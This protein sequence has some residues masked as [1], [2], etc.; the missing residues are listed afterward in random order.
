MTLPCGNIKSRALNVGRVVLTGDGYLPRTV[1]GGILYRDLVVGFRI[2]LVLGFGGLIDHKRDVKSF[3]VSVANV[4]RLGIKNF[5][6]RSLPPIIVG[7]G[8][9]GLSFYLAN[10]YR[11]IT[12]KICL[13]MLGGCF[14]QFSTALQQLCFNK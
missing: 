6:K 3:E 14:R 11:R 9:F 12:E 4:W 2:A 7:I 5:Q 1:V 13:Y 10:C 8:S